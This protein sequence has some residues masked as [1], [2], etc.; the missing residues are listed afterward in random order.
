MRKSLNL[1]HSFEESVK[2][3]WIKYLGWWKLK[4]IIGSFT[5]DQRGG[6]QLDKQK[7][8]KRFQFF[9][10]KQLEIYAENLKGATAQERL[11]MKNK[12]YLN[13]VKQTYYELRQ[14]NHNTI[15]KRKQKEIA[16]GKVDTLDFLKRNTICYNDWFYAKFKTTED[17]FN[18]KNHPEMDVI[19]RAM[20]Y[21]QRKYPIQAL[22][23]NFKIDTVKLL[24]SIKYKSGKLLNIEDRTY[25]IQVLSEIFS[26]ILK[27]KGIKTDFKLYKF[28]SKRLRKRDKLILIIFTLDMAFNEYLTDSK[29]KRKNVDF[30]KWLKRKV[31]LTLENHYL[32]LSSDN[33]IIEWIKLLANKEVKKMS[34]EKRLACYLEFHFDSAEMIGKSFKEQIWDMKRSKFDSTTNK[35]TSIEPNTVLN[36]LILGYFDYQSRNQEYLQSNLIN[37]NYEISLD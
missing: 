27:S 7:Q 30:Y 18:L 9:T 5:H 11:M 37:I 34:F 6:L 8:V 35:L 12:E 26:K 28:M 33:S 15:K 13:Q 29:R 1:N 23:D 20:I 17:I 32:S 31:R 4:P 24:R 22:M 2:N 3:I 19:E 10:Q 14:D 21:V 16:K 36:F 25:T